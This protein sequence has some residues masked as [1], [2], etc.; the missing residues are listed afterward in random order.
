M[1]DREKFA[2]TF[3]QVNFGFSILYT[4]F[5][6]REDLTV[7][8]YTLLNLIYTRGRIP[9]T[10]ASARLHVSKP[11]ITYIVD[12]LE[13]RKM[14]KRIPCEKDRR[15]NLLHL[16]RKG[17]AVVKKAQEMVLDV[18]MVALKPFKGPHKNAIGCFYENLEDQ[19]NKVM[20]SKPETKK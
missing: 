9:M 10:E 19:L 15:V 8:Q 13:K 12:Q 3:R 2:D 1:S 18:L 6:T 5:L 20:A 16:E 14:L 7:Q 17:E 11:A 4:K